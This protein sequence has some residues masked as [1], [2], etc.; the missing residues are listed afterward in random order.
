[1]KPR[2]ILVWIL[3]MKHT[4]IDTLISLRA[5]PTS[6][7]QSCIQQCANKRGFSMN[8]MN[9]GS[10][11]FENHSA[12][13]ARRLRWINTVSR[14]ETQHVN[15]ARRC[16]SRTIPSIFS[17]VFI[18]IM[19]CSYFPCRALSA[20]LISMRAPM[21]FTHAAVTLRHS[22]MFVQKVTTPA[23]SMEAIESKRAGDTN[24]PDWNEPMLTNPRVT[25]IHDFALFHK[26]GKV[27]FYGLSP[28]IVR[29]CGFGTRA[30]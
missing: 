23:R 11:L 2:L 19:T 5:W 30:H 17:A 7:I 9:H 21:P 26:L 27:W 6:P 10:R 25:N 24:F 22:L 8:T 20:E 12:P 13:L 3:W 28:V 18:W 14:S 4:S 1:M 16:R 29:E 15:S